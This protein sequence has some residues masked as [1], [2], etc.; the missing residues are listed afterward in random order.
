MTKPRPVQLCHSQSNQFNYPQRQCSG[1]TCFWA[2]WIRIR[3]HYVVRGMDPDPDFLK[4]TFKILFLLA[5]WRS[6][7]KIEGSGSFSQM[8]GSAGPDPHRNVMD[9]EHCSKTIY[10]LGWPGDP[11][12]R[13]GVE[14]PTQHP[15]LRWVGQNSENKHLL[16][17]LEMAKIKFLLFLRKIQICLVYS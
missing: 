16:P 15:S 9:P 2:S 3:I 6:M 10:F 4:S 1:S 5:S 14:R 13:G 12:I 7:M 8:H 17:D 11:D